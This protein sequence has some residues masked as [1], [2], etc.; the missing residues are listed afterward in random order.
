M[1]HEPNSPQ[2]TSAPPE[3]IPAV[4]EEQARTDLLN[5]AVKED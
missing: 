5:A 3:D 2:G 4:S 1:T